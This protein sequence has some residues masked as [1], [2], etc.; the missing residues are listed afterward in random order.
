MTY[1]NHTIN[2]SPTIHGKAG[3]PLV[4][5]AMTAVKFANGKF[6]LPDPGDPAIGIVLASAEDVLLQD[7]EMDVQI[8]DICYWIAG[9]LV[10]AGSELTTG[11]GGL[12]VVAQAGTFIMAVALEDGV[13]GQP[14]L[15]QIVKAGYKTAGVITPV[16][17]ADCA[18]VNITQN[19]LADGQ[20]L[21]YDAT[22]QKWVN[23]NQNL[24]NL[25]DVAID[26]QTLADGQVITYDAATQKYVNEDIPA[27]G[28]NDLTDVELT[29][30]LNDNDVVAYDTTAAKFINQAQT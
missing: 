20:A 27:I 12:A 24:A 23:G 10:H 5:P 28:L 18:D 17:L 30:P 3:M 14:V 19:Q 29:A 7:A 11:L 21:I 4:H 26:A 8:K 2:D 15:V 22:A 25:A 9:G 1:L 16:T 6:V 13:Q